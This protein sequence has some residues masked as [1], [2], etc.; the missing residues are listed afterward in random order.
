MSSTRSASG[1]CAATPPPPLTEHRSSGERTK[2][3]STEETRN[4]VAGYGDALR[5]G[6]IDAL[7][8]SFAPKATWTIRGDIPVAG[9][10]T[11]PDEI[12]DG[13]LAKVTATLDPAAP[14]TQD[15]HR[16]IADGEHAVAAR[17]D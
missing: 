14:L 4:V 13:L 2:P 17:A 5:R 15:L 12:H 16:I 10:C 11:G 6:D 3:V 8:A 1:G 7:R 9:T